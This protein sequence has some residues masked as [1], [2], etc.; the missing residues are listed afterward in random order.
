LRK[1]VGTKQKE[2][3]VSPSFHYDVAVFVDWRYKFRHVFG[4]REAAH[5][6]DQNKVNVTECIHEVRVSFIFISL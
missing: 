1:A 6:N 5:D 2:E 3:N 4:D